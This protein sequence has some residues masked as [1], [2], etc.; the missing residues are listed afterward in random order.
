MPP[1]SRRAPISRSASC[2]TLKRGSLFDQFQDDSQPKYCPSPEIVDALPR[3]RWLL[4]S[5]LQKAIRRG[6]VDYAVAAADRLVVLEPDYVAGRLPVIA[7][8]DI[9]VADVPA[10]L[11]TKLAAAAIPVQSVA[12]RRKIA[13]AI[14]GRL[15]DSPKSRTVCDILCLTDCS[16]GASQYADELRPV[17]LAELIN[18]GTDATQP[19]IKRAVAWRF[20]LTLSAGGRRPSI[21]VDGRKAALSTAAEAMQLPAR[22]VTAIHVGTGTHNLHAALALAYEVVHAASG[23]RI[24]RRSSRVSERV[25]GGLMLC[26][27]DMYTRAGRTAYRRVLSLVPRLRDMLHRYAPQGDPVDCIA[28]LMFHIE[29]SLLNRR[30][31]SSASFAVQGEVENAEALSVGF[32]SEEGAAKVRTWLRHHQSLVDATR[33]GVI[34]AAQTTSLAAPNTP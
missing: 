12:E 4:T 2:G 14:A 28:M 3:D 10:L 1:D 17:R 33:A 23:V 26:A 32:K 25:A 27:L 5:L 20:I 11:W 31:E 19:L 6:R 9:G 34:G 18:A 29:G 13:T 8:E 30:V 7:Y 21:S 24:K 15:A 16:M 22:V